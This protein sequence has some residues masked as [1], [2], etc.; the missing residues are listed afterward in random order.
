MHPLI[1]SAAPVFRRNARQTLLGAAVFTLIGLAGC[2]T[3]PVDSAP[4]A[5]AVNVPSQWS[6]SAIATQG[7]VA[8]EWWR[9][10]G[11]NELNTLIDTALKS[12][13]DLKIAAARLAQARALTDGAQAERR[14]QLGAVAGA[15]RGRETGIDPRA[16]RSFAGL[17]AS[18]EI[19]VFGRGALA[20]DAAEAVG[21][22]VLYGMAILAK[23][24]VSTTHVITS[25]IMGAGASKRFS[26]VRWGVARSILTAWILTFP[27]AGAVSAL[28]Y[29]ILHG[30]LQLP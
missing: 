4:V 13:R 14:P 1:S 22:S 3:A 16:E 12:N 25:A 30:V 8:A 5:T 29:L 9:D 17:R 11:S 18:W 24:P 2:A 19:D 20:I 28:S 6:E 7:V 26:A 21:S 10:F 27:A 15:Q 23:A